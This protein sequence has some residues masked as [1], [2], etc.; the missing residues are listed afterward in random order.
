MT[1]TLHW[2]MVPIAMLLACFGLLW[3]GSREGG[4]MGGIVQFLVACGLFIGAIC[5]ALVGWLK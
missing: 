5:T 3:H 4:M 1:V 2:W